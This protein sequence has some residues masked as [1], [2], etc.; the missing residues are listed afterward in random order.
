MNRLLLLTATAL[1]AT[2]LAAAP[3]VAG[4]AHN[5][6]FSHQLPVRAPS[7]A[8]TV[9]VGDD[10]APTVHLSPSSSQPNQAARRTAPPSASPTA[11][12]SRSRTP[13][14]GD[15]R[16][17]ASSEPGDDHGG[18]SGRGSDDHSGS[19]SSGS[20]SDDDSGSGSSGS[21]SSG[22]NGSHDG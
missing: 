4:L 15:D 8:Q 21:D 17:G 19:G 5:P 10:S 7:D 16:G 12:P 2:G 20:G 14:P 11:I 13:E 6:S 9:E 1:T 3:A 22:K 18:G